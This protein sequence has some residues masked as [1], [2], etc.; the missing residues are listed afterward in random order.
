MTCQVYPIY[1]Y[2]GKP[3]SHHIDYV[4]DPTKVLPDHDNSL[5][6]LL[7]QSSTPTLQE[8]FVT[9]SDKITAAY[10]SGYLTTPD[11]LTARVNYL[12]QVY[13]HYRPSARVYHGPIAYQV[14]LSAA[15]DEHI[16]DQDMHTFAGEVVGFFQ[17]AAIWA[18]HIRPV[19]DERWGL[20]RGMCKHSHILVAAFPDITYEIPQKLRLGYH[21]QRLR[22]VVDRLAI[23]HG[24]QV[25]VDA[26]LHKSSSYY[27]TMCAK[28]GDSWLQTARDELSA[29]IEESVSRSDYEQLLSKRGYALR[30]I[31][32]DFCYDL[33]NSHRA[34]GHTLGRKYTL[35]SLEARW[36]AAHEGSIDSQLTRAEI[37]FGPLYVRIPLG[38]AFK[39]AKT[40]YRCSLRVLATTY[41]EGSLVSYFQRGCI[42]E[43]LD[44]NGNLVRRA[45]GQ[46]LLNYL[47]CG[48][49]A[50][51]RTEDLSL[52][53]RKRRLDW[54]LQRIALEAER[55]CEY[56]TQS[57]ELRYEY[58]SRWYHEHCDQ[59]EDEIR[60]EPN[61][62]A[63][64]EK[65]MIEILLLRILEDLI[66]T[67]DSGLWK[68]YRLSEVRANNEKCQRSVDACAIMR[69]E[70]IDSALELDLRT[71]EAR[72]RYD[73][74]VQDLADINLQL[75]ALHP[76]MRAMSRCR[77][78]REAFDSCC[79]RA[80]SFDALCTCYPEVVQA[81][82]DA[83]STVGHEVISQW[84]SF[85]E[86]SLHYQV[87]KSRQPML[88]QAV[89]A[90]LERKQKLELAQRE[91]L[92][93][94]YYAQLSTEL[95]CAED[96]DSIW[97]QEP[98]IP[99]TTTAAQPCTKDLGSHPTLSDQILNAQRPHRKVEE[100]PDNKEVP[101]SVSTD[102]QQK[103]S[104]AGQ[105][106]RA[107]SRSESKAVRIPTKGPTH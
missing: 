79:A 15:P 8:I 14:V 10:V 68:A 86:L 17:H 37:E 88:R 13:L 89:S 38:G 93:R 11:E 53:T 16:S 67:F 81:Y 95:R 40:Y 101:S 94:S 106:C 27:G 70:G 47:G 41:L 54:H 49:S 5:G 107:D 23:K 12:Q 103:P 100:L 39:D 43:I 4:T 30:Q 52:E 20:L 98:I 104:L 83:V 75:E 33:P 63:Y 59:L 18:T 56:Y 3:L 84:A 45:E 76:L 66:P 92:A 9:E 60:V 32:P 80:E 42:Y 26:D 50:W 51:V 57:A 46:Q 48:P 77:E 69:A 82:E 78:A 90:E 1:L 105:M 61:L 35:E 28:K 6:F 31:G 102:A 85:R 97:G 65:T 34:M 44:A 58:K 29:L 64:A 19:W 96:W 71:T 72:H 22:E 7:E 87:L 91:R 24:Y 73:Q 36:A 25:L 99:S 55:R 2:R 74:L 62:A 21:Y